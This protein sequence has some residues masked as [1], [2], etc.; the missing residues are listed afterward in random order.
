MAV[1]EASKPTAAVGKADSPDVQAK[2]AASTQAAS[3]YAAANAELTA[4]R[5]AVSAAEKTSEELRNQLASKAEAKTAQEKIVAFLDQVARGE[6]PSGTEPMTELKAA[7]AAAKE[8]SKRDDGIFTEL[9]RKTKAES[10]RLK[11]AV[12][13]LKLD[14]DVAAEAL[15]QALDGEANPSDAR[16]KAAEDYKDD[17]RLEK[18]KLKE[19]LQAL[20]ENE[21]ADEKAAKDK[22]R[23]KKKEAANKRESCFY[24]KCE[25][26]LLR[27]EFIA[28]SKDKC[29]HAIDVL[30]QYKGCAG[31]DGE[32]WSIP[33]ADVAWFKKLV[34]YIKQCEVGLVALTE[35]DPGFWRNKQH[36]KMIEESCH[37]FEDKDANALKDQEVVS[38]EDEAEYEEGDKDWVD[39]DDE[40]PEID[41]DLPAT[42]LP[43]AYKANLLPGQRNKQTDRKEN[44]AAVDAVRNKVVLAGM[45][46]NFKGMI[47]DD[48]F[49]AKLGKNNPNAQ[50]IMPK[51]KPKP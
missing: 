45:R 15:K 7:A 4:A 29:G 32:E 26:H 33:S 21:K 36:K 51:K 6:D 16:K 10:A 35:A 12:E 42:T 48:A 50:S 34:E 3:L 18:E 1:L 11:D 40:Q 5:K 17:V 20:K 14:K 38:S 23:E 9:K 19:K 13:I 30:H 24:T 46:A 27:E 49:D 37:S 43:A 41:E 47:K 2:R 25:I 28:F 31:P 44:K 22:A 8:K 39:N